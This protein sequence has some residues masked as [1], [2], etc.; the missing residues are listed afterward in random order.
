MNR[1]RFLQSGAIAGLAAAAPGILYASG[2]APL[3]ARLL[4]HPGKPV[5]QVPPDFMGLS[6]ES[7]QLADPEY[8]SSAN[9]SLIALVRRLGPHGVLRIGGNTS[10]YAFW[11]PH[12]GAE[13][14]SS[15]PT[16][17]G[18]D[19]GRRPI[20]ATT[21]TPAAIRNLREFL[22]ATGWRGIYGLNLGKGTPDK[23]AD[24]G[25]Y[26]TGTL[27]DKLV[28][29]QIGNEVE[30]FGRNG[31]RPHGYDFDQYA[32]DWQ[33]FYDVIHRRAPNARFAGP[34]TASNVNWVQQFA[35]RFKGKVILL[36]S[37][38]YAL[39]PPS[40][41]AMT[42][43]RLLGPDPKLLKSIAGIH[44]AMR[45]SHLPFRMAETNSC[46]GG[47]KKGV[48]NTFGAALWAANYMFQLAAARFSGINFHGGG[49][50]WYTP[51][52]GTR[53]KGFTARPEYYGLLLFTEAAPRQI[54]ETTLETRLPLLTAYGMRSADGRLRAAV[55]N[56]SADHDANLTIDAGQQID[57]A[58]IM[59]LQGP[60]LEAT[61]GVT[62][63]GAEVSADG[64]WSAQHV[65]HVSA[66]E[67]KV[68]CRIPAASGA[69]ISML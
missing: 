25:H 58:E 54:I 51:I 36:T 3:A 53:T 69:L 64:A 22:D 9:S 18:P 66:R 27:G 38:H 65:E 44:D 55:F 39:G 6:Y 50:G 43:Q 42:L 20:R 11:T 61:E 26:V 68:A 30:L 19:T 16:A 34:D 21:I 47:G 40:N 62:L 35:Q 7:A 4:L 48:S 1:R 45:E 14:E 60:R 29:L 23:A 63:G 10:E 31:L 37:H 46:Y 67:G 13:T 28:A 15:M 32:S 56:K 17:V 5:A 41:P 57:H 2:N 24:E 33:R 8:F 59:R 12:T 52:A 49:Y